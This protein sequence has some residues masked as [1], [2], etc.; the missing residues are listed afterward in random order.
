M[1]DRRGTPG[2]LVLAALTMCAFAANSL[3]NR[4]AVDGGHIAPG[5]FAALR[6]ASG[7]LVLWLLLRARGGRLPLGGPRRLVGAVALTTYMLGF[8]LAY[9]DLGAGA[10]ALILF[11]VVQIAMFAAG[12]RGASRPGPRALSGAGV[13]LAGLALVLW[14]AGGLAPDPLA[15]GLMVLAGLGWAAYSLAGRGEPD[16]LAATAANFL[17]ALPLTALA[18]LAD[19]GAPAA[20][21]AGYGLAILSGAVTSG[22][23]YALWYRLLPGLPPHL[24]GTLQL[25]VPVIALGFGTLLLGETPDARLLVGAAAVIG[26][27]AL[28]I[29]RKA[30]AGRAKA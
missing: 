4:L 26:G 22:L 12:L 20:H 3:L 6:V 28:S 25:S 9:R 23:G 5:Q 11:A 24:A 18:L 14:P 15:A 21:G 10:G 29:P 7:A 8:S 30:A 13:A 2:L 1:A 19:L 27:I 16:A 17:L